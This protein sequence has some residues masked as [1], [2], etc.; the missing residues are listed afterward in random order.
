MV[1]QPACTAIRLDRH[2][3]PST[4]SAPLFWV[5][6]T[7]AILLPKGRQGRPPL[8]KISPLLDKVASLKDE[9]ECYLP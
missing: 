9:E 5:T 3:Y 2:L 1:I 4:P 6:V 7:Q 8:A